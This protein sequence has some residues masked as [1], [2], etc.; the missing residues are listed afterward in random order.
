[1]PR[2]MLNTAL[3]RN[4]R[5]EH[6]HLGTLPAGYQSKTRKATMAA[7]QTKLAGYRASDLA[8]GRP[9]CDIT[10][11]QCYRLLQVADSRCHLCTDDM[12]MFGW[13]E[14]AKG[15]QWTL[16]RVNWRTG[17]HTWDNVKVAHV[18]CNREQ[19]RIDA[20]AAALEYCDS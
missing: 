18:S 17:G 6:I 16:D 19:G 11:K 7:I 20:V 15:R 2:R 5:A 4:T 3:S 8:K 14:D 13:G 12:L 10:P 9:L 1:M